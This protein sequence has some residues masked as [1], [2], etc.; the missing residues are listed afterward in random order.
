[1]VALTPLVATAILS[2]G[3]ADSGTRT[4]L[5][6]AEALT[7]EAAARGG[8]LAWEMLLEVDCGGGQVR[9]GA[10]TGY[11]ARRPT[12]EG[13]ELAPAE[14]QWRRPNPGTTLQAAWRATC[15]TAFQPPLSTAPLRFAQAQPAKP[16]PSPPAQ[17]AAKPTIPPVSRPAPA[18]AAP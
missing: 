4:V 12:G 10:T 6:R 3:Q 2:R 18:A 5:L 1:M 16:P 8:V 15:D 11:G 17:A 14:S 13:V 9:L 7:P